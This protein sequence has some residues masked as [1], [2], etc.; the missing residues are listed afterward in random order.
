MRRGSTIPD[1][2]TEPAIST[3][4]VHPV[5]RS[6]YRIQVNAGRTLQQAAD[7]VDHL[8]Q[9]G[10]DWIYLSPLLQ[11][12]V[13]SD[14]G[15]DVVDH[16]RV[17]APRG[18]RR[19]LQALAAAAHLAG[20][21]V[22]VDIVPNH[23]GVQVP[24]QSIWWW[25]VLARGR[26]S[27]RAK[28][29]DIDWEFGGGRIRIP[30]LGDGPDE[31]GALQVRD[32][33]L[34]YYHHRYPIADGTIGRSATETARQIHDRQHYELVGWR[35]ED[36]ELNYR[37]F[38]A[39]STLAAIR[40]ED[41]QVFA[42][43]HTQIKDWIDSGWVDGLRVDHPDGLA[44]PAGY[45]ERLADLTGGRYVLVEK[46]LEGGE[47]LPGG[48]TCAGTT[49]YDALATL[50]R[51]F[52]DPSGEVILDA[53]DTALRGAEVNWPD[54]VHDAKRTVANGILRSE[55]LRLARAV[56]EIDRADDAIAELLACFPV[57]R[58]YLPAGAERLEGAVADAIRRRSD[59]AEVLVHLAG[60][61]R[62]VGTELSVRFQQTSGMAMA[63]G[64]EDCSFY[65]WS[66]LT[67]LTE[68]GADPA[69]FAVSPREFHHRQLH[70]L[71]TWP[72]AMTARSTHDT[73]RGE[74]VRAR[75]SVLSEIGADWAEAVRRWLTL[76][77]LPDGPLANLLLQAAVGAWPIDRERLHGYA[78]KASREAGTST[79]WN[80][81][82]RA[83]EAAMHRLVD[84][85][86]D[87]DVLHLQLCNMV[88]RLTPYGWSNSLSA[89]LIALTA[90][91]V[92]DVY[93]GTEVWENSLVDPDN[94]RRVDLPPIA[95]LLTR[96]D[97]GW[98]PPIDES[99]AAKLLVTSRALRL[100]RDRAHLFSGYAPLAAGGSA[101]DHLVAFDR[102]G[103]VTIAT[104]LPVSLDE[105][106]GWGETAVE[107]STGAWT[108]VL[109]GRGGL[110]GAVPVARLLADY[111]VALLINESASD[112]Q[113]TQGRAH[114][115]H[116]D[117]GPARDEHAEHDRAG[118]RG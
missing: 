68:V 103:A 19:G 53:L 97:D 117:Q 92:P 88:D 93:Q 22:L 17:D 34:C 46:I 62:Q 67:S 112:N 113:S 14:H 107:L 4:S 52:I 66:R 41:P 35:R 26:E 51:L 1:Q 5:P 75:I 59:L 83:F 7:A 82:D 30:V 74:D 27:L 87:E 44:D 102:G 23:V 70:R 116:A 31:L 9:L 11:S 100:R 37:R 118:G 104:R 108:D 42:D 61:L 76:A 2:H 15:Y 49:G 39:V 111:P 99:G 91:G 29:F 80:A 16:S 98:Q 63:K 25:D 50:D 90:P 95:D 71:R 79:S 43:S 6:T 89:K 109:T 3:M 64:V 40:V 18:G 24:E 114:D 47:E 105:S 36:A 57:Y 10:A 32:G 8:Q 106:G 73:K 20:I 77:P 78:E 101:A 72:H 56:P 13:G 55:V 33:L 28:A 115:H 38:F 48:W 45:L 21:G 65:R 96:I 94:R 54:L 60:R 12:T 110:S 85:L 84:A 58:S 69:E 81:P 86:Y